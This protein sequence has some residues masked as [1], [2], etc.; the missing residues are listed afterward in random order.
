[1]TRLGLIGAGRWGKNIIRTLSSFPGARL[2]RVAS[3]NPE[4]SKLAGRGCA[5]SPDWRELIGAGDLDGLIIASPPASHAQ[6]AEAAIAAGLPVLVEKPLTMDPGQAHDLLE[7]AAR[8]KALIMVDH[9]FLFHPAYAALKK[10][11]GELGPIK[12]I[13]S[14]GGN[15]GPFRPDVST[16]WD[17]AP[18]DVS[19]CLD[20]MGAKPAGI[21][22]QRQKTRRVNAGLG[23]EWLIDLDFKGGVRARLHASNLAEKKQRRL[24]VSFKNQALVFDDLAQPKLALHPLQGSALGPGKALK[25]APTPPL[26][27][28]LQTF[29]KALKNKNKNLSSLRLAVDV[30]DILAAC[31][32]SPN[33]P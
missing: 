33:E 26:N 19:L 30:V 25:T 9:I 21:G 2:T 22:A 32:A 5:V 1:M 4:T 15:W 11:S 12:S 3:R 31:S 17:Y 27:M 14:W 20:L 7:S 28:V 8:R 18:H 16:L 10:K 29:V 6:I 24:E 23:E 13:S